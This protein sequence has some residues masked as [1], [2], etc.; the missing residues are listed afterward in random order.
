MEGAAI[1]GAGRSK[2]SGGRCEGG[3]LG[4]VAE[5]RLGS[6]E[7]KRPK[8]LNTFGVRVSK[9]VT[10][11]SRLAAFSGLPS[12]KLDRLNGKGHYATMRL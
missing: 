10:Y 5:R 11:Q 9:R 2:V 3:G 8:A 7:A 1:R 4:P 6:V 12:S